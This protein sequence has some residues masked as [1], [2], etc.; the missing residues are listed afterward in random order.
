VRGR[1]LEPAAGTEDLVHGHP[2]DRIAS[3]NPALSRGHFPEVLSGD[4]GYF[5]LAGKMGT[6]QR[7]DA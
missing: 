1:L 7:G 5:V 2:L 3:V 6:A 4:R